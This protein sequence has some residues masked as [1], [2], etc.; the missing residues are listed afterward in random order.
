MLTPED[1]ETV[2]RAKKRVASGSTLYV[3]TKRG[4]NAYGRGANRSVILIL[5]AGKE[6]WQQWHKVWGKNDRER[7][8]EIVKLSTITPTQPLDPDTP[9]TAQ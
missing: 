7:A 1:I 5:P 4:G 9:L 3:A 2:R 6:Q 8:L